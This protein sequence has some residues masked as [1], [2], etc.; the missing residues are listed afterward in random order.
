ML[1]EILAMAKEKRERDELRVVQRTWG[2]YQP[3]AQT[4]ADFLSILKLLGRKA[5]GGRGGLWGS[6]R[7]SK[8]QDAAGYT[9]LRLQ[10]HILG[11]E[12]ALAAVFAAVPN[13]IA[14][15]R[16]RDKGQ[17]AFPETDVAEEGNALDRAPIYVEDAERRKQGF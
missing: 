12:N 2:A 17:L 9:K 4:R 5:G 16:R 1:A 7:L 11:P 14:R 3:I 8:A 10:V 13:I 15:P 6:L